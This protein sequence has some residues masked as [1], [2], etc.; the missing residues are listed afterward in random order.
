MIQCT[1]WP[2]EIFL[3]FKK[4]LITFKF[5]YGKPLKIELS[6]KKHLICLVTSYKLKKKIYPSLLV[7]YEGG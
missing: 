5:F 2:L 7:I 6:N 1:V 4:F 3:D